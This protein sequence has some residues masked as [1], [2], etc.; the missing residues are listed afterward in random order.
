LPQVRASRAIPLSNGLV[1]PC[2][3]QPWKRFWSVRAAQPL[4]L[5]ESQDLAASM[6]LTEIVSPFTV[7]L[8]FTF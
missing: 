6:E 8:M 3:S 2:C 5:S 7:P 4:T 1:R